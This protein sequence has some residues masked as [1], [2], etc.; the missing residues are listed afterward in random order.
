MIARDGTPPHLLLVTGLSGAGRTTVLNTL[1]DLGWEAVEN[2]PLS[3]LD[4]LLQAPAL[5]AAARPPLALGVDS[6]TR[7]FDGRRLLRQ[8]TQLRQLRGQSAELLFLDCSSAELERRFSRTRRRHPLAPDR[9][10]SDGIVRERALL[11]EVKAG[12]DHL[13]DTTDLTPNLL[14]QI[15]RDR[16][17][18]RTDAAP[19]LTIESFGF[20]RGLP[21]NADTIFDVRFLRNPFWDAGLRERTGRDRAVGDYVEQDDDYRPFLDAVCRLLDITVP[22]AIAEGKSYLTIAFGCT[23]GRHR[24]VHVA[25][26][27]G[28]WLR[29]RGFAPTVTHRDLGLPLSSSEGSAEMEELRR[30]A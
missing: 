9:P 7:D 6:R 29:G 25:E 19:V 13:I 11:A 30:N 21:R 3:L 24:S 5:S 12:A 23:G 28:A 20:A 16:F 14:G 1:E 22:R 15:I 4:P 17:R 27:I 26:Q 18:E 2:L 10:I 8:L